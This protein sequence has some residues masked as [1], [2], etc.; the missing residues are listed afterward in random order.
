MKKALLGILAAAAVLAGGC[1]FGWRWYD[2]N[3]DRSGWIEEGNTYYYQDFHGQR[4]TGWQELDG[5]T[6]YF[7]QDNAMAV[8]WQEIDGNRYYFGSNGVLRTGWQD[9]G[10]S[11]C[12]FGSDG[13]SRTG[14]Q[15]IEGE[16][17]YF[18][19]S[20]VME[21]GWTEIDGTHYYFGNSGTLQ[22]GWLELD[23][24]VYYLSDDGIPVTGE[25]KLE[26]EG[27]EKEY[28]FDQEG[29]RY[30]GWI[31]FEDGRRYYGEDGTRAY[32]WQEIDGRRF[33]LGEDGVLHTGWWEEGEYR[34]YL[35]E[36]GSAAVGETEIDGRTY[37]FTPKGIQVILV[38]ATHPIPDD[39]TLDL[40]TFVKWFQ[41]QRICEEPLRQMLN[42]CQAAGFKYSFNNSFRSMEQQEEIL[43]LRTE[44]HMHDF[45]LTYEQAREK[46]L[47]TVA[48]P[49][50]S[51]HQMGLAVDIEGEDAHA[52]LGEHCW[53]YG[54]ILRYPEGKSEITGITTEPWHF[55]YVGKEVSMDM[56]DT[57]LC[58]EEYLG[59]A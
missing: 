56:K 25:T 21:T 40:V 4:V 45:G 38:N 11:R 34:Y 26:T 17:Y 24:G 36:D 1:F 59:A 27:G 3:V 51:E 46:A 58:L 55:R 10:G 33:Y 29:K 16:R 30:S 12:Y 8:S 53:E 49:G 15:N 14:W 48:V 5:K 41:V 6:Y 22:S 42:D 52:W 9:I 44:E 18:D 23:S 32:G 31:D 57:G 37:Y 19:P 28:F 43:K 13:I 7:D 47:T 50:T 2:T 35:Q 54:F 20:G 39:Y